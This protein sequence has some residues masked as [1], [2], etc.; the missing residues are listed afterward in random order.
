MINFTEKKAFL[1]MN[2]MI[3]EPTQAEDIMNKID[4][5]RQ[6]TINEQLKYCIDVLH[7]DI[8]NLKVIYSNDY[9]TIIIQFKD[10]KKEFEIMRLTSNLDDM[11]K[12]TN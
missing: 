3:N 11:I 9:K 12:E 8:A 10:D 6:D 7:Y 2:K 1:T 4:K 5:Q